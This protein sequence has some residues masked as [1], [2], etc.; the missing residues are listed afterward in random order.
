MKPLIR[1]VI[2]TIVRLYYPVIVVDGARKIPSAG[3]VLYVL[4]HPNGLIDPLILRLGLDEPVAFLGKST[5][6]KHPI[7]RMTMEA[8]GGIPVY[9]QQD[10]GK[11]GGD[12]SRN[13]ETF[14]LC[15]EALARGEKLALFPEG[16]TH[17]DPEMKPLKTGA[18]RIA[19]SSE[20]AYEDSESRTLD[21]AVVPIGL[22]YEAKTIFRSRVLAVVGDPIMVRDFYGQYLRDERAAVQALTEAER[23]G[24]DKV[25]LQAD[26]RAL[27]EGIAQ[28]ASFTVEGGVAR[29][30]LAE[31]SRRTRE[32]IEGYKRLRERDPARAEA[33]V[34][35]A[36]RYMSSLQNV[37]VRDPWALELA[38]PST[39]KILARV[40]LLCAMAPLALVGAALSWAPYR[41]AGPVAKRYVGEAEDILGTVKLLAGMVFILAAWI[42]EAVIVAV[43]YGWR[44]L[45]AF[46]VV[47]PLTGYVCLRF[48]ERL[49]VLLDGW[50]HLRVRDARADVARELTERRRALAREITD[51][52]KAA[53]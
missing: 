11:G 18:A 35:R 29:E 46:V 53:G 49:D 38:P 31:R 22:Q 51:A 45:A 20:K 50:S 47:A 6:F 21:L 36:Q 1:W 42:V 43:L 3:P 14:R 39:A 13:E 23:D 52:L 28:V 27:L 4:N 2:E 5:L 8:F 30:D 12:T 33:L 7:S 25:V 17:S 44:A 10:E 40:L 9:R 15:R 16:T 26:T 19:L 32:L 34:D 24:L 41:L 37:G 48:G